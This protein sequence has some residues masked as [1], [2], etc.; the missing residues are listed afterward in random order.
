MQQNIITLTFERGKYTDLSDVVDNNYNHLYKY[1]YYSTNG[2]YTFLCLN[3]FTLPD[4][5]ISWGKKMIN[6]EVCYH[7]KI[8]NRIRNKEY[9][10][11][12]R[13]IL[14]NDVLV[15]S[16]DHSSGFSKSP[17]L[18]VIDEI[19]FLDKARFIN[20]NPNNQVDY[21]FDFP[22]YKDPSLL[23]KIIYP[24]EIKKSPDISKPLQKF[25]PFKFANRP[26]QQTPQSF[27]YSTAT[28]SKENEEEESLTELPQTKSSNDNDSFTYTVISSRKTPSTEPKTSFGPSLSA[29]KN[30]TSQGGFRFETPNNNRTTNPAQ[31]R[32]NITDDTFM[33]TS[34]RER[35]SSMFDA[36]HERSFHDRY[37][38]LM[39][40][41]A[42]QNEAKG[43]SPKEDFGNK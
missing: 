39:Q 40:K 24:D 31:R 28:Q 38:E 1:A 2:N 8:T 5:A 12:T 14:G 42:E 23:P 21:R 17:I 11:M 30:K 18:F 37:L 19:D 13:N 15:L 33:K 16:Q 43:N 27:N 36:D 41:R 9:V 35:Y 26:T 4:T 3:H 25:E 20:I 32:R 29:I 6:E 22:A 7:I 10:F 34:K